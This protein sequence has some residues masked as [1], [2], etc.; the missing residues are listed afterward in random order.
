[1]VSA[2]IV[3]ALRL[4][5]YCR[6]LLLRYAFVSVRI[7]FSLRCC[8]CALSLRC[9]TPPLTHPLLHITVRAP[10][11]CNSHQRAHSQ[12]KFTQVSA[13]TCW[14]RVRWLTRLTLGLTTH[15]VR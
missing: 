8:C 5:A 10:T 2:F 3:V 11:E 6:L 15:R 4:A 7:R 12:L 14:T 1:M 13:S 9:C